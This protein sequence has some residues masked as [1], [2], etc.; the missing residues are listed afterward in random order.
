[1]PT[2]EGLNCV[3]IQK[4]E[5]HLT[6]SISECDL[7]WNRVVISIIS[8]VK[9]R[10]YWCK[11]SLQSNMT[12]LLIKW[13]TLGTGTGRLLCNYWSYAAISPGHSRSQERDLEQLLPQQGPAHTLTLDFQPPSLWDNKLLLFRPLSLWQFIMAA[14]GNEYVCHYGHCPFSLSFTNIYERLHCARS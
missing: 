9:V 8:Q 13:G 12:G 7:I 3:T 14:P 4:N 11:E 2:C 6:S 5:C 10:L 1:M